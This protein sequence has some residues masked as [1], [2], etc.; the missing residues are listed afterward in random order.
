MRFSGIYQMI[1]MLPGIVIAMS[2]HEFA[3]A[4]VAY[5]MGDDTSS[6]MG[7]MTINPLSHVDP[8]GLAMLLLGGF[9]WAR[10]VPINENN[11]SKRKMGVFLVSIAG[12]TMN[13]IVAIFT[14]I[15]YQA[16]Q[17]IFPSMEYQMVMD[18]IA[19]INISFA[20]FNLLP[21]PPLDGSKIIA[22][23]LPTE[24][25]FLFYQYERYGLIIMILLISTGVSRYLLTPIVL[26]IVSLINWI[27]GLVL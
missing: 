24:K 17:H 23:F 10:P 26:T 15:I 21:I 11:F 18:N 19:W 25:R 27:V 6:R 4:F 13:I 2:F 14:I 9:G 8:I 12:V 5:R 16:T 20:A 22:A 3:H 1:T 7:R